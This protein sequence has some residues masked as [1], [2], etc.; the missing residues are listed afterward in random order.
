MSRHDRVRENLA[1]FSLSLDN[2]DHARIDAVLARRTGPLGDVFA[3][4]REPAGKHAAI[5]RNN[6]NRET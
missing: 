3:L 6:L 1:A 4:E 5:M 2:E